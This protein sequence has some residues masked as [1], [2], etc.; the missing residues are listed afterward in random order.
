MAN[1]DHI[2]SGHYDING[3][4]IHFRSKWEANYALYLDFLVKQKHIKCWEFE[5]DRFLFEKIIT[6]TRTYIPDFKIYHFDDSFEYHEV[7]GWLDSKSKTKLKR[8]KKYFPQI[9]MILI[10]KE[11]YYDIKKKV[12]KLLKFY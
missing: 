10:D 8:M 9:K 5:P 7:K 1:F 3:K 2:Q 4:D 11:A 12:G 6:G